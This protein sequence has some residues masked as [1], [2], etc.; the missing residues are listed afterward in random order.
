LFRAIEKENWE[1]VLRFLTTG[2]WTNSLLLSNNEHLKS[3]APALQVKTWV[4]AYDQ[5][6]VPEWSQLPLH[7]A[8]SYNAPIVVVQKLVQAYPKSIQCTDN[9]GMLPIHLAFGFG[10]NEAVL[11][12]LL[13]PF[14]TSVNE[15]GL[16]GRFPYECCEL[17]PNKVR[18]EVFK[19]VADQVAERTRRQVDLEWKQF[20]MAASKQIRLVDHPEEDALI[21]NLE[22]TSLTEFI[23]ELLKD[24]KELHDVKKAFAAEEVMGLLSST[25]K[26]NKTPSSRSPRHNKNNIASDLLSRKSGRSSVLGCVSSGIVAENDD[27]LVDVDESIENSSLPS[28]VTSLFRGAASAVAGRRRRNQQRSSTPSILKKGNSSK[29]STAAV[30]SSIATPSSVTGGALTTRTKG[31]PATPGAARSGRGQQHRRTL[32]SLTA[33]AGK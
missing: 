7:A 21:D 24:R 3:P 18:G 15:R 16:G 1:G 6:G 5:E 33:T 25:K 27:L 13:E 31:S 12:M 29:Q 4:T 10:A 22:K 23:L 19:I 28:K 14:P 9:E 26:S 11:A 2:K 30:R 32:A 20:S 17:G 8:I